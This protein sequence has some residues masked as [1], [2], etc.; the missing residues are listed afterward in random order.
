MRRMRDAGVLGIAL[1]S[2]CIDP[3]HA[4]GVALGFGA[5]EPARIDASM[6]AVGAAL[7]TLSP[8]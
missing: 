3:A 8:A 5:F 6:R 7:A 4:N 1:S 2:M